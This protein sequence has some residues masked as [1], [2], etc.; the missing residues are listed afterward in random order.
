[1]Q[2]SLYSLWFV[3]F[4]NVENTY[5]VKQMSL[6]KEIVY[7]YLKSQAEEIQSLPD[8]IG[9]FQVILLSTSKLIVLEK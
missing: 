3:S 4:V 7:C 6:N 1:M 8:V 9:L 5:N 2:E